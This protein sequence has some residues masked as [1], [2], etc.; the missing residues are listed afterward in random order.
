M[1]RLI[2]H[3][4]R[5]LLAQDCVLVP[6]LGGFVLQVVNAAYNAEEEV[7]VPM[8]KEI[9]FNTTLQHNDGLLSESYMQTY[10]VDYR[11]AQRM[12]EGDIETLKTRLY[13]DGEVS[14]GFLGCFRVGAEGKLIFVPDNTAIRSV[15]SYGLVSFHLPKLETV[16]AKAIPQSSEEKNTSRHKDVFY[17]PIS[18]RLIRTVAGMVAAISLFLLVSTPVKEVN[19]ATYKASFV[20]T[21]IV[22]YAP[23]VSAKPET[24]KMKTS[25]DAPAPSPK[26]EV[27]EVSKPETPAAKKE[28][29][30]S[31]RKMYHI[32]IASFPNQEQADDYLK[33]VDKAAYAHA[34]V[35]E[36]NG[37][38][39]IYADRF[40]NREDAE[41]YLQ[42]VRKDQKY[43][44]AWLFISR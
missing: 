41:S 22:S 10:G 24:P 28:A 26:V 25:T 11:E 40:D 2:T 6:G 31:N 14:L 42:T 29:P 39:R 20:P 37:K 9:V 27:T 7:F 35:I 33:G 34:N 5:L 15:Y 12:V 32:V 38:Y 23:T 17:I 8:Q 4:E 44:D 19:P 13:A 16:A 43:K 21:E 1:L 30:K 3:I 18:R 36:R